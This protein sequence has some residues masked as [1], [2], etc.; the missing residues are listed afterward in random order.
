M[1][2]VVTGGV[3]RAA[4]GRKALLHGDPIGREMGMTT[5]LSFA[6]IDTHALSTGELLATADEL[7][8]VLK[9]LRMKGVSITS[10]RNHTFGE[11]PQVV[12]VH[13][14]AEGPALDLAKAL[15]FVL[16]VQV[17]VTKLSSGPK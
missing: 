6:G 5:W 17:G 12:F 16:E 4:I 10:I 8:N 11:H 2:G 13:F 15:R 3:Y 1:R 7:Q 14:W 9:A